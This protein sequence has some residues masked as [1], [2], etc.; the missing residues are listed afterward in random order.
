MNFNDTGLSTS[1]KFN[2][3]WKGMDMGKQSH[4]SEMKGTKIRT[5]FIHKLIDKDYVG[6]TYDHHKHQKTT[7]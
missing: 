6:K 7:Q 1:N 3:I 4:E 2:I 5:V